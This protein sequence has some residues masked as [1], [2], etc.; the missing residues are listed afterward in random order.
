MIFRPSEYYRPLGTNPVRYSLAKLDQYASEDCG[1]GR[2]HCGVNYAYDHKKQLE[3]SGRHLL[4]KEWNGKDQ[5][6]LLARKEL[7]STKKGIRTIFSD[8]AKRVT[9][10]YAWDGN[11][12]FSEP[13]TRMSWAVVEPPLKDLRDLDAESAST[14]L[15]SRGSSLPPQY[16]RT[17][18]NSVSS[19]STQS[20]GSHS[21]SCSSVTTSSRQQGGGGSRD[22][23]CARCPVCNRRSIS[24]HGSG[25]RRSTGSSRPTSAQL[26]RLVRETAASVASE[27]LS[28]AGSVP[29]SG[30]GP[31]PRVRPG[32]APLRSSSTRT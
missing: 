10:P 12:L 8:A 7:L 22:G 2:L 31:P 5:R 1:R 26:E 16:R 29:G 30:T 27:T 21:E 25:S 15:S 3:G 23:G 13:K 18:L 9:P 24:A 20:L 32:T 4:T 17:S 19:Y 14:L 11:V 28:Q 6:R